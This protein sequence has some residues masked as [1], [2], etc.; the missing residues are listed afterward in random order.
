M[1][2]TMGFLYFLMILSLQLVLNTWPACL[3][4]LASQ[5]VDEIFGHMFD[6]GFG[7]GFW[8]QKIQSY[9]STRTAK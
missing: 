5:I 6:Q 1:R 7:P 2:K 8:G 9:S 4:L 3:D